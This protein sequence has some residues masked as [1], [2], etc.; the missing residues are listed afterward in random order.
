MARS[1]EKPQSGS[2]L[3]TQPDGKDCTWTWS[4]DTNTWNRSTPCLEGHESHYPTPLTGVVAHP[5]QT[6]TTTTPWYKVLPLPA[7]AT[8]IK[9]AMTPQSGVAESCGCNCTWIWYSNAWI[10]YNPCPLGC[11]C[12]HPAVLSGVV[13]KQGQTISTTT[14]C[15]KGILAKSGESYP[16]VQETS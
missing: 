14:P 1:K 11:Q 15:F 12:N 3:G 7:E 10:L 2:R 16:G 9:Q 13:K 5:G 6:I 8:P 4:S